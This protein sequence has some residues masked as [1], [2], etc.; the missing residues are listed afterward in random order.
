MSKKFS[1]FAEYSIYEKIMRKISTLTINIHE[2]NSFNDNRNLK[3][4]HKTTTSDLYIL[5]DN[6]Y[7]FKDLKINKILNMIAA[8]N[9]VPPRPKFLLILISDII[10]FEEDL[11]N[12]FNQLWNSKFLDFSI[13][14]GTLNGTNEPIIRNYN[15]FLKNYHINKIPSNELF[16][17]KLK[18]LNGYKF[19]TILHNNPPNIEFTNDSNKISVNGVNYAFLKLASETMKFTFDYVKTF[20][21]VIPDDYVFEKI[22]N[23]EIDTSVRSHIVGS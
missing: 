11:K 8:L 15:P 6:V 5:V 23:G 4:I 20:K 17:D 13:L 3:N 7:D 19:K 12:V 18:N 10:S 21:R 9:P 2:T 16:P 1:D 14:N 22:K